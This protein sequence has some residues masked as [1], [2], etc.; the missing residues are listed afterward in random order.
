MDPILTSLRVFTLLFI[1]SNEKLLLACHG[2]EGAMLLHL[3]LFGPGTPGV[4]M[5]AQ[6][7]LIRLFFV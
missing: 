6:P 7:K 5:N 2:L 3:S 4:G 1:F